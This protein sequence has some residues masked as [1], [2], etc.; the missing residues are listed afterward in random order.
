MTT[1]DQERKALAKIARIIEELGADSYIATACAGM[2]EDARQNIEEDAA[3]S[4]KDR[5]ESA[6]R[7]AE[8]ARKEL[9]KAAQEAAS[10][11]RFIACA[12]SEEAATDAALVA[13]T[14]AAAATQR[15]AEIAAELESIN[16]NTAEEEQKALDLL[17]R[18][19]LVKK[20]SARA[21]QAA[22][23]LDAYGKQ[24]RSWAFCDSIGKDAE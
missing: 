1:K 10:Y 24:C 19:A 8:T 20:R 22:A 2:L 15:A 16:P 18:L 9:E 13:R 7:Q 11:K 4:W 17:R 21:E 12:L 14:E 23:R 6:Q 5:A 3:Y